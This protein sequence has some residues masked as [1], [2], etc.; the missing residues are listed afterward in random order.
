MEVAVVVLEDSSPEDADESDES[1]VSER[2]LAESTER[3]SSTTAFPPSPLIF[4]SVSPTMLAKNAAFFLCSGLP[5][6][7]AERTSAAAGMREGWK[8]ETGADEE[9]ED[10]D[11]EEEEESALLGSFSSTSIA[12]ASSSSSSRS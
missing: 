12:I 9:E 5:T 7:T 2:D 11:D 8:T 6:M 3:V 1:D 10:D 4:D